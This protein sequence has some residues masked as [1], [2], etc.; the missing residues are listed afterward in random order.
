M[1]NDVSS[2][3]SIIRYEN[4]QLF[5]TEDF[6]VTEFPLTIMVNGEEFATIICS[7]TNMEEL[8][9]GFLASEGAILKRDELKSIQID[10]SKGF[11]HVELT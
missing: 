4:G 9:L 8:V 10:D 6:Y 3:Q 2:N 1:N 5:A 7:P 11:A